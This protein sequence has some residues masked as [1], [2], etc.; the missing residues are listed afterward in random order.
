MGE[1]ANCFRRP[2]LPR[3]FC[4]VAVAVMLCFCGVAVAQEQQDYPPQFPRANATQVLSNDRVNVWDAYWLKNQPTPMHRHIF[5]VISITVQGGTIRATNADGKV[6]EGTS[7]LGQANFSR[8]GLT[9]SEEG[10]SDVPQRKIFLELKSIAAPGATGMD[11]HEA[12][13]PDGTTKLVDND[14]LIAWDYTW[15]QK[16]QVDAHNFDTVAV[17]LTGGS[18]RLVDTKGASKDVERKPGDVV[19]TA[20]GPESHTEEAVSG[21]PRAIVVQLK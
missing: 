15:G 10:L 8:K 19:Y 2:Q 16:V 9:H 14:R 11:P 5:D 13:P 1:P 20:H 3:Y 6:S 17:F 12:F 18:I 21:A 7:K 4:E